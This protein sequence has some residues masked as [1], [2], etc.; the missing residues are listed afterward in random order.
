MFEECK[1]LEVLVSGGYVH[2]LVMEWL[3]N[4]NLA[5]EYLHDMSFHVTK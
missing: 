1:I 5:M 2:M 3:I 4:P